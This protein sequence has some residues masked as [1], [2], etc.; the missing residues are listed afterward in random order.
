MAGHDAAQTGQHGLHRRQGLPARIV[1]DQQQPGAG[2]LQDQPH[3][4][5]P[6]VHVEGHH[7]EAQ[8]LGGDVECRPVAAIRQHDRNTVAR[9]QVLTQERLLPPAHVIG[10]LAPAPGHPVPCGALELP[11]GNGIR[12]SSQ[13]FLQQLTQVAV[14]TQRD[15]VLSL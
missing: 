13:P 10:K 9:T 1:A 14:G 15:D 11:V 8:P 12:R 2:I 4:V 5:G 7:H 3:V 6:I